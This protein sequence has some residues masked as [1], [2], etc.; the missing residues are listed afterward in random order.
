VRKGGYPVVAVAVVV[1]VA[2]LVV[3]DRPETAGGPQMRAPGANT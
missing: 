2:E 3:A 1:V